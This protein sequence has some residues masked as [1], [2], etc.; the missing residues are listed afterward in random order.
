M[1][2]N[3]TDILIHILFNVFRDFIFI[4]IIVINTDSNYDVLAMPPVLCYNGNNYAIN[5]CVII[6]LSLLL[7]L[8]Y[9]IHYH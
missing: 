2:S 7:I 1:I 4:N 6:Y 9:P 5:T 8:T 3:T